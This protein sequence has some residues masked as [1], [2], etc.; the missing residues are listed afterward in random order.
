MER[1]MMAL[2]IAAFFI[3]SLLSGVPT[4]ASASDAAPMKLD[5]DKITFDDATGVASAEGSVSVQNSDMRLYAPYVEYDS[6]S[7]VVRAESTSEGGITFITKQGRLSGERMEY[8]IKAR[9]G[10]FIRPNGKVDAFYVK[11]DSLEVKPATRS[12]VISEKRRMAL[13]DDLISAEWNAASVTTCAYPHPHYRFEASKLTVVEGEFVIVSKPKVFMGE[14]HIFSYPFDYFISLKESDRRRKQSIFPK[15]G[16]E[17]SKGAGLGLSAGLGWGSGFAELDAI[18]WTKNIY[19]GSLFIA[20][21][22]T[23]DMY[24]Y[25][26]LRRE[27]DKDNDETKWRPGWGL[28]YERNGWQVDASWAQRSLITS[29]KRAGR[30]SRYVVWKEPEINIMSP[31]F[32]DQVYLGNKFRLMGSWGRY[33]DATFGSTPKVERAGLGAQVQGEFLN[34]RE[35]FRPFYNVVYW[36]YRYDS[37][38]SDLKS[39]QILEGVVG[40]D[41]KIGRR[42][43]MQTAYLRRWTWGESPMVWDGYD[44]REEVYQQVYYSMPTKDKDISWRLGVRA[45]YDI[46]DKDIAEMVYSVAYDQHCM[47][48]EAV[49]R[50]DRAGTD[51]WFGLSLTINAFPRSGLRLS[52]SNIYD[53]EKAPNLHVPLEHEDMKN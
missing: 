37:D 19:E 28:R 35:A 49:F 17:S 39:Q 26:D 21:D 33:E 23:N 36:Y 41:W 27:Y 46:D 11:G 45:A 25:A 14:K 2:S 1:R 51:D 20:Q 42:F 24:V 32:D 6:Y 12:N 30:D 43:D 38:L 9:E 50:D 16:Y 53:P 40:V 5:A 10:V 13:S 48:W 8:D 34:D 3:C 22:I 31:W 47:L 29:E 4:A 15:L 52:G 7:G 44:K 18:A